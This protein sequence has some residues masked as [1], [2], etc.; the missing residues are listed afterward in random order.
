MKIKG[1]DVSG[2][3]GNINWSKVAENGVEFAILKVIRKDLQPDKYFEANWT[4]ATEAGVPVQGVYNYSYAT[5]AEKAQTDAQRVIEVLGGRN[6]MVWLDVED[7][8]QQNIGD[9]IVSII[10]EYQKIIEAAGCKFGVYTGLSFYNSYIKPYL[11]HIDC[12]F[13]VAR[14][15]SSTPMMITADAPEDKKPDILHELYGW[16]YSSKGFVAGV[17]GCVD[18]NELYVAVDTVNVM[19][20]PENTLH[21]VGEEITVSSYYKSS[22]AGIGDA[23][24]K[25]ASGTITRIKAGTHNPYCFSK[26]GVAVGWCNDGDIRSTDSSVMSTDKKTTYTVRRGDTLSKI[27]KENNVTV[28]Q[29]QKD[30]GIKNP[31]KIYVGQKILI[32]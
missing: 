19:P 17:S 31:N 9:K 6:V 11:E 15:P 1:I 27:A 7:K 26:N 4:G 23:I 13:W 30:N 18:L 10:N 24:I 29:L 28:A 8:C 32:Q 20:D 5:N 21:K 3:N 2:Y 12:P 16:Q 25:Y 22:T 14:Y